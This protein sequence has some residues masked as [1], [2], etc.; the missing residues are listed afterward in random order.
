[1]ENWVEIN[2]TRL[3]NNYEYIKKIAGKPICAVIKA[4]GYGVGSYEIAKELEE[5][6]VKSF[7]VAFLQEALELRKFGIRSEILVLNYVSYDKLRE[8]EDDKLIFSIYSLDQ[9]KLRY[10]YGVS[11]NQAV[12][13]YSAYTQYDAT[14]GNGQIA[15]TLV[16]GNPILKWEK[17]ARHL[18]RTKKRFC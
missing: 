12:A 16:P 9:L 4:D 18:P 13:A 7:A 11:G 10:G 3:K 17:S 8:I 2:L 1:M 5:L 14:I 6:G 15:Y